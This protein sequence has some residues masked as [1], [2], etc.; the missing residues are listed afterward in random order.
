MERKIIKLPSASGQISLTA[1]SGHFATN[2]SHVNYY[3][4]MTDI[5]TNQRVADEIAKMLARQYS[6]TTVVNAIVCLDSTQMIG[7]FLAQQ[8]SQ[9]GF[10]SLNRGEAIHVVTPEF[11]SFGQMMFR[12]NIRPLIR[13]KSVMLLMSSVTTGLTVEQGAECIEYYGG[14]LCGVSAIFSAV[15]RVDDTTIHSLF[16]INDLPDYESHN[17]A[18]CPACRRGERIEAIINGFGYFKI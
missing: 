10:R 17:S 18:E 2:H 8:L 16:H 3:I 5:K 1:V 11:N 4:D 13:G 15:D 6:S 9:S 14:H 7:G 12:D